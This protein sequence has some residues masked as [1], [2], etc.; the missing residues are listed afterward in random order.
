MTPH[1]ASGVRRDGRRLLVRVTGTV[2]I[3]TW[4]IVRMDWTLLRSVLYQAHWGWLGLAFLTHFIGIALSLVRWRVLLVP[5]AIF[6]SWTGLLWS[7]MKGA[8]FNSFLPTS[9]GGDVV[10]VFQVRDWVGR[11]GEVATTVVVERWLGMVAMTMLLGFGLFTAV[12]TL[13]VHTGILGLL[14]VI[15]P[16]GVYLGLRTI[17][18]HYQHHPR[19]GRWIRKL[20]GVLQAVATYRR[21]TRVLWHALFWSLWIQLD[22]VV[23]YWLVGRGFHVSTGL[24][25]YIILVPLAQMASFLP[26]SLWGLGVREAVFVQAAPYFRMT[27]EQGFVVSLVASVL[28]VAF[29]MFG[30]PTVLFTLDRK[31]AVCEAKQE[32]A[33]K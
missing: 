29:N 23:Y 4:L 24:V 7:Y 10:R 26:I 19:S 6:L 25:Q 18:A 14:F 1:A 27:P 11:A 17:H 8:F 20:A 15:G 33:A 12:R 21:H 31:R 22:V 5:Q 13:T 2:V 9:V 30:L 32:C 3:L 16:I 28:G